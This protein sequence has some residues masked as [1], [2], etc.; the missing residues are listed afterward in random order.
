MWS[1][2]TPKKEKEPEI[3]APK[4]GDWV[5]TRRDE[6]PFSRAGDIGRVVEANP[7]CE[8][9]YRVMVDFAQGARVLLGADGVYFKGDSSVKPR[10]VYKN[11]IWWAGAVAE[12]IHVR[13]GLVHIPFVAETNV[14]NKREKVRKEGRVWLLKRKSR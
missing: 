11:G 2:L 8:R 12:A 6:L 10:R 9:E 14:P 13:K 5:M 1:P 7:A 4:L 3:Y